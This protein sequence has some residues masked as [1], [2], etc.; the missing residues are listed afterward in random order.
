MNRAILIA[1]LAAAALLPGATATAGSSGGLRLTPIE[2]TSFPARGYVLDLPR[3][4]EVTRAG[5]SVTE[6]GRAVRA[7]RLTSTDASRLHF[8]VVLVI[9]ASQSMRGRPIAGALAAARGF[10]VHQTTSERVGLIT[11]NSAV[12]VVSPPSAADSTLEA[13]LAHPPRLA[14]GT[15]IYDA[16]ARAVDELN[17]AAVSGGSIVLL[18]DGTDTGSAA[19]EDAVLAKAQRHHVRIFT[20]GLRSRTFDQGAMERLASGTGGTFTEAASIAELKDIYGALGRRLASEYVLTYRSQVRPHSHVE[21]RVDVPGLGVAT[22]SYTAPNSTA[23]GA[24]HRSPLTR[25]LLS[26]VSAFA[27]SLFVGAMLA[28]VAL[29]A[30]RSRHGDVVRRLSSFVSVQSRE[31]QKERRSLV[32]VGLVRLERSLSRGERWK[33]FE[34]ALEIARIEVPA[35]QIVAA[36]AITTVAFGFVGAILSPIFVVVGLV[37]P[38][39]AR[40]LIQ[41]RLDRV[42]NA[43]SEQLPDTLQVLASS[44]RAGHSFVGAL[45]VVV[46]E[47]PDPTRSEFQRVLADEQL[48]VPIEDGLRTVADRMASTEL[49]QVALVAELQREA[50]GNMAE[51]LDTVVET[52]R[53]RF[54]LRRLVKTLTAQGR[55]ARW[56][57]SLLPVAL[58]LV[59]TLLNPTY[60]NPLFTTSLGRVLI[61]VAAVMVVS[62]SLIIKKIVDIKV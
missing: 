19:G 59:L 28:V 43:F 10:V 23:L 51:V 20:V 62:G 25:F 5:I 30:V 26:P 32:D 14:E 7:L 12:D 11:F 54:D 40:E 34:R 22:V 24:F 41:R 38:L 58:A 31:A 57:V 1:I 29:L 27:L 60:M 53:E 13:A 2:R 44:L 47:A 17:G 33:R 18:S 8:G 56:I 48:G 36:T 35:R 49:E 39:I 6:N 46:S 37:V 61:L 42:R 16:V 9:D 15:Y 4:A 50:G 55:M 3:S 21:V 45:A 52:I